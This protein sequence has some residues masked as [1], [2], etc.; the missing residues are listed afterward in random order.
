[1]LL[2]HH[3]EDKIAREVEAH[4][5]GGEPPQEV[6]RRALLRR[7]GGRHLLCRCQCEAV[8]FPMVLID[9]ASICLCLFV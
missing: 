2:Q 7:G 8:R 6:P 3:E 4:E 9:Q 5:R 1:M